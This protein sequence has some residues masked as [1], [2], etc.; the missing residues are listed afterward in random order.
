VKSYYFFLVTIGPT[1]MWMW[2]R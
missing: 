2:R 1:L